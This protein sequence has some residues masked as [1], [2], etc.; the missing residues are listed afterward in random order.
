MTAVPIAPSAAAERPGGDLLA[1]RMAPWLGVVSLLGSLAGYVVEPAVFFAAWLAAAW[2]VLGIG[3]GALSWLWIHRLTGGLWGAALR[4]HLLR[5]AA[6]VPRSLVLF[7]PLAFG[8][9]WLYPPFHA[10]AGAPA[11][12]AAWLGAWHAPAFL[13]AR[14]IVYA[15]VWLVLARR[16]RGTLASGEAAGSL[17]LHLVVTTL[18]SVD[19]LA[20]LVA[21]WSSSIFGL[22]ALSGQSFAALAAAVALACRT[23]SRAGVQPTTEGSPLTRD[24]GN[25][26][27]TVVMLWAYLSFMQLLII[28]AEDLPREISWYVPRLQ[29]G[30]IWIGVALVLLHFALPLASLLFRA[31]KDRPARLGVVALGLVAAH[32]L[33]AAWLVLPSVAPHALS[34]WWITPLSVVGLAL[35]A[36]GGGAAVASE[37]GAPIEGALADGRA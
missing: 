6:R 13:A 30:W 18:A 24:F 5:L 35:I 23:Q 9:G 25:L 17:L 1:H 31:I 21:N 32:A 36:F 8:I 14:C 37:R 4:P 22:L 20:A 26:L 34:A 10:P 27:L 3:A 16:A 29:T 15:L 12:V 33:D 11:D 7:M 19:L 2:F 28:W